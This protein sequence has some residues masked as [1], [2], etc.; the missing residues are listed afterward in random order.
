MRTASGFSRT[1]GQVFIAVKTKEPKETNMQC[2]QSRLKPISLAIILCTTLAA[3]GGGGSSDTSSSSTTTAGAVSLA[4]TATSSSSSSI[5]AALY[6]VDGYAKVAGVTGGGV[7]SETAST[8][9]KVTTPL[10]F[11]AAISKVKSGAVKVIEIANDL[12]LG[13]NEVGGST[14]ESTYSF[15]TANATAL[16]HP[17][18]K[19]SGVSKITI[20]NF[21][22]LTIYSK[23]GATIKHAEL[24]IKT[25]SNLIIRNLKFDEMWEWDEDTKGNYDTND[26]DYITIGDTSSATGGIWIDH[27]TFYKVY[28]GI[29]DIKKGASIVGSTTAA[30][31]AANGITISWSK[32]LP[33]DSSSGA[34]I[35]AQFDALE[36]MAA[37]TGSSGNTMY[38]FLRNYLTEAQIIQIASTQKKGHLIG[39]T[40]LGEKTGYTVTLHHDLYQDLQDRMPRLRSG[41]VQVFNLYADASN[42]RVIKQWYDAIVAANATLKAKVNPDTGDATYHFG[43]TSNG[44]ISTE[45][46][47]VQV[48]NSF[49][50]GVQT[51]LRNNQQCTDNTCSSYTGGIV[52][53]G[54]RHELLSS[55]DSAYMA[56]PQGTY[57]DTLGTWMYWAGAS[58]DTGSSLGPIQAT[59]ITF[60]WHN[61]TPPTPLNLHAATDLPTLL[62]N[63]AG[64]GTVSLTAAQWMNANN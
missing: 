52:A 23:N 30:T 41:D 18:L 6:N 57:T 42:A 47:M 14:V 5:S 15:F 50:K 22:G 49:Y 17:T 51:P 34:F 10:E 54:T 60:A 2:F 39:A 33:G 9:A 29:V 21:A 20:Q 36:A 59:P 48:T 43:I 13:Y 7:I 64:A 24:N 26:W 12:N 16:E 31:Q 11:L 55:S 35:K 61:G 3:C 44:S 37:T 38:K 40:T 63:Y 27:C 19:T 28:D 58:S 56:S 25:G 53:T 1:S 46:G 4:T 8:Y 62:T 45:G 32:S